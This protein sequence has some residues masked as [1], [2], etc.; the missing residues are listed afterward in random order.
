MKPR[1]ALIAGA[2]A[3]TLA[4]CAQVE[5]EEVTTR[6]PEIEAVVEEVIEDT[7]T[8]TTATTAELAFSDEEIAVLAMRLALSENGYGHLLATIEDPM[9]VSVAEAACSLADT[10]DSTEEF[11]L[12]IQISLLDAGVDWSTEEVVALVG[13]S[14][15]AFCPDQADRLGL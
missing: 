9:I 15:G 4:G 8:T 6:T 3:V 2:L 5:P 14:I 11:I 1:H 13:A 7:P 12:L 10:A